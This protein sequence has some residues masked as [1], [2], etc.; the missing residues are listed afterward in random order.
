MAQ[1]GSVEIDL[2]EVFLLQLALDLDREPARGVQVAGDA[3]VVLENGDDVG[4]L[5]LLQGRPLAEPVAH[6]GPFV[7]N[8]SQEIQQAIADYQRLLSSQ[9]D[10]GAP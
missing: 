7:M 2:E 5:L 9:C 1:V 6:Y 4:E 8:S 10:V 3:D